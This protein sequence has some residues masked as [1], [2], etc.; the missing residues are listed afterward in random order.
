MIEIRTLIGKFGIVRKH[1]EAMGKILRNKKLL[2]ILFC[3]ST[4]NHFP[5]VGNQLLIHRH[6]IHLALQ[7]AHQL[8]LGIMYLEMKASEHSFF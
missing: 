5:K 4:P 2:F 6:I 3:R 1:Q 8:I 7:D